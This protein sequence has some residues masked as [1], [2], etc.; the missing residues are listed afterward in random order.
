MPRQRFSL[1]WAWRGGG[2]ELLAV[3]ASLSGFLLCCNLALSRQPCDGSST[4]GS[5]G[6][7]PESLGHGNAMKS[8]IAPGVQEAMERRPSQR[9]TS[10]W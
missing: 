8:V 7:H 3:L 2:G 4:E 10:R 5:E 1:C 9:L 6:P